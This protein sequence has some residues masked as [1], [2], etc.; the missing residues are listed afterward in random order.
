ME[1]RDKQ[2]HANVSSAQTSFQHETISNELR[3]QQR[4][5]SMLTRT[6][7]SPSDHNIFFPWIPISTTIDHP[8]VPDAAVPLFNER[9]LDPLEWIELLEQTECLDYVSPDVE[10]CIEIQSRMESNQELDLTGTEFIS[11]PAI[12][13]LPSLNTLPVEHS[14]VLKPIA[15]P[16]RNMPRRPG[17]REK[18]PRQQPL[19][20]YNR[21][22]YIFTAE[23]LVKNK[24]PTRR[25]SSVTRKCLE[26]PP[27]R[28]ASRSL[29]FEVPQ[30][31]KPK[32]TRRKRVSWNGHPLSAKVLARGDCVSAMAVEKGAP[33]PGALAATKAE[34]SASRT[35]EARDVQVKDARTL[36]S[37][38]G[39]AKVTE[40]VKGAVQKDAQRAAKEED[41][42]VVMELAER[43]HSRRKLSS[44]SSCCKC[45]SSRPV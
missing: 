13:K 26:R 33:I 24:R 34:D 38:V 6:G 43:H 14:T 5:G 16:Q 25:N 3:V 27:P 19:T 23:R 36:L 11:S 29:K 22:N 18:F 1:Q 45:S 28:S 9:R 44:F 40:V 8:V 31:T 7:M 2:L 32:G 12:P 17:L 4:V 35:A 41:F 39:F 42:V 37:R 20:E 30:N 15:H 21:R 10:A